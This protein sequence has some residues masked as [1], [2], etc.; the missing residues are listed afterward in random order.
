MEVSHGQ[1]HILIVR[2]WRQEESSKGRQ[3]EKHSEKRS[4]AYVSENHLMHRQLQVTH[5]QYAHLYREYGW[6][7]GLG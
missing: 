4:R 7:Y 6:E 5:Y 1:S 2:I 3:E